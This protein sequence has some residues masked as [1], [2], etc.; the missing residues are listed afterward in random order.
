MNTH[1]YENTENVLN[2][3]ELDAE[4]FS[5]IDKNFALTVRREHRLAVVKN[6]SKT[7]LRLSLK[8]LAYLTFLI[9]ANV[10]L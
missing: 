2:D 3:K 5:Q 8:T 9:I 1:G 10:I 7:T 4:T 6:I